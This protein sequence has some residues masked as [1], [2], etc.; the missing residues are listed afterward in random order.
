MR[1]L[2]KRELIL[3]NKYTVAKHGGQYILPN[4]FLNEGALDYLIDRN[5]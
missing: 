3:V 5:V 1:Y 4:N 2:K